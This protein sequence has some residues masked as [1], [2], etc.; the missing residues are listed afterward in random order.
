MMMKIFFKQLI[1]IIV[2]QLA[3]GDILSK[4]KYI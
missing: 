2:I 3:F 4:M 1:S